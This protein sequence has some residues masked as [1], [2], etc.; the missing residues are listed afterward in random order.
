M[1]RLVAHALAAGWDPGALGGTFRLTEA[2]GLEL[3]DFLIT[4][5][6]RDP[7]A[8]DPTERVLRASEA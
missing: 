8:A 4:D 5:R 1:R 7:G 6:L 3:P 2:H